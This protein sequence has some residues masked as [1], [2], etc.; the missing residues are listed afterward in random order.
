MRAQTTKPIIRLRCRGF[1][2]QVLCALLDTFVH[3]KR[4]MDLASKAQEMVRLSTM[5]CTLG[6][7]YCECRDLR[8][9]C[10]NISPASTRKYSRAVTSPIIIAILASGA[11]GPPCAS[12][13]GVQIRVS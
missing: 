13:A 1:V 2:F 4:R 11:A 7:M 6:F 9:L 3:L 10:I 8:F 12:V 5:F